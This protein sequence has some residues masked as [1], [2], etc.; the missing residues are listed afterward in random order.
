[1]KAYIF[2]ALL[3]IIIV[4][5]LLSCT[6]QIDVNLNTVDSVVVIEGLVSTNSPYSKVALTRTKNFTDLNDFGEIKDAYVE[7]SDDLDNTD[8]LE[9][10]DSGEYITNKVLGKVGS[11]YYLKITINDTTY[12]SSCTIPSKVKMDS[13]RINKEIDNS[14]FGNDIDTVY[15][16][17]VY[18]SDPL[19][20]DNYYQLIAYK[21][22]KQV[23]SLALSDLTTDGLNVEQSITFKDENSAD[24]DDDDD[25]ILKMGDA[26][27]IEMRCISEEVYNY[28]DDLSSSGMAATPTNPET[29][30]IGS[31][32]GYFSAHTSES[33]M[34]QIIF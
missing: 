31:D 25:E 12:T 30:I 7:L 24:D 27:V 22:G 21:N 10:S 6:E 3:A 2:N 4:N 9:Q 32:L 13:V 20:Q 29:N 15:N 8:V 19:N 16:F 1:M 11:T 18:Y 5:T 17:H 14:F 23:Y 26:V 28:L 33:K 34:F